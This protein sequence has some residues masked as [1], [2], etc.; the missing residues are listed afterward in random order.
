MNRRYPYATPS[1]RDLGIAISENAR[2]IRQDKHVANYDRRV[3]FREAI[4]GAGVV[5]VAAAFI[6]TVAKGPDEPNISH[7]V[8]GEIPHILQPGESV[9]SIAYDV[10]DGSH[11]AAVRF[12]I[13]KNSLKES[14]LSLLP[15]GLRLVVPEASTC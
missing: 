13:E 6:F 11:S 14:E 2:A 9:E 10:C 7:M 4:V 15:T 5:T 8:P 1:R 3:K 12:I